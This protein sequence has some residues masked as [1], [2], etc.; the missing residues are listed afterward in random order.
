MW[1]KHPEET[2][3][4]GPFKTKFNLKYMYLF[5]RGKYYLKNI[6]NRIFSFENIDVRVYE[7]VHYFLFIYGLDSPSTTTTNNSPQHQAA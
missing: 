1:N 4:E 2:S 3:I 7:S 6:V 5:L